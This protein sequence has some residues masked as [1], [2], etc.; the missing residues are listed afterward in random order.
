MSVTIP[1]FWRL[2]L[3]SQLLTPAQCQQLATSFGSSQGASGDSQALAN[4]LIS[5]NVISRYQATVLLAGRPGPFCYGEYK[6]YDRIESGRL[7]GW[8]RAVHIATNHPVMLKFLTGSAS[9]NTN[10]WK[11]IASFLPFTNHPNLVR[12]DRVGMRGRGQV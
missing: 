11:H 9:Q 2:V 6:I 1:D 5:Q 8:F 10:L 4:W 12:L 3:E 7:A